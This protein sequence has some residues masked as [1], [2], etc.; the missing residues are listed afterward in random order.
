MNIYKVPDL[1]IS[2]RRKVYKKEGGS[3]NQII[4][5]HTHTHS[6]TYKLSRRKLPGRREGK[7]KDAS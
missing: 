7:K 1:I 3:I 4:H 2:P 5:T 6:D